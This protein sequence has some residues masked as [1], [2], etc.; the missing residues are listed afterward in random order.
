MVFMVSLLVFRLAN[1]WWGRVAAALPVRDGEEVR[2]PNEEDNLDSRHF[3][4]VQFDG[5]LAASVEN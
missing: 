2:S 5:M 3:I 1:Q 4:H